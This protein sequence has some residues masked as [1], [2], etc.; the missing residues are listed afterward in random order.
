MENIY[1][2]IIIIESPC[3]ECG[4]FTGHTLCPELDWGSTPACDHCG[5]E[6]FVQLGEAE[7]EI[8]AD[9]INNKDID[10]PTLTL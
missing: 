7:Q 9:L 6:S 8:V 1:S 5:H 2:N 4:K 10:N 3:A